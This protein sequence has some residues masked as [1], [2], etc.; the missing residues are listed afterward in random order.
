[1]ARQKE[2]LKLGEGA[3]FDPAR[4]KELPQ[5]NETWEADFEALPKPPKQNER[6]F[7]GMIVSKKSRCILAEMQVSRPSVNDMATML[8]N[9]MSSPLSGDAH[10][11][12]RIYAR[13]YTPW[14]DVYPHLKEIGIK[15][16]AHRE[17]PWI[18]LLFH[19][20]LRQ[21]REMR[22]PGKVEPTA[23]QAKVAE[24]FPALSKFVRECGFIEIG[25]LDGCGF[26]V[27]AEDYD[28]VRV[29]EDD[30]LSTLVEAMAA[31]EK[32]LSMW[33][34]EKKGKLTGVPKTV[35]KGSPQ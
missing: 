29:F 32:E 25:D 14:D 8:A 26:I 22:S 20:R 18:Y 11:P 16:S 24:M 33:F 21:M 9:A 1:M 2:K 3:A 35:S 31:L 23:E 5:E 7:L 30:N 15:V 34:G 4:L 27:T 13:Y 6:H 17:F 12:S 28:G 19:E 10:R